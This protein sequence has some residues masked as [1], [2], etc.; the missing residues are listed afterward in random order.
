ML[1]QSLGGHASS[2]RMSHKPCFRQAHCF[3]Q[4]P[5]R[6]LRVLPNPTCA[7]SHIWGFP[8][9]LSPVENIQKLRSWRKE[10]WDHF[11]VGGSGWAAVRILN[12][13]S[14][15]HRMSKFWSHVNWDSHL[16]IYCAWVSFKRAFLW[17]TVQIPPPDCRNT[18]LWRTF[19]SPYIQTPWL[20][21]SG[22]SG[23]NLRLKCSSSTDVQKESTDKS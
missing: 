11:P 3:M 8:R 19:I 1:F 4:R 15:F 2:R 10:W 16:H 5:L 12:L 21:T 23:K 14:G 7:R 22:L 9:T 18:E 17:T 6:F 20:L 13:F